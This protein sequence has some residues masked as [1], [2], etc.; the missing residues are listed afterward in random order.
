VWPSLS[1]DMAAM[2]AFKR[3]HIQPVTV[4]LHLFKQQ[5]VYQQTVQ[6]LAYLLG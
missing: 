3:H 1:L 4:I 6:S 2:S 5:A